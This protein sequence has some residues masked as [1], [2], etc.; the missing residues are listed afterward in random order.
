MD[1]GG[2]ETPYSAFVDTPEP[3]RALPR[4]SRRSGLSCWRALCACFSCDKTPQHRLIR[5][6]A[7]KPT[8]RRYAPNSVKNTKYSLIT[9]VPKL[10]FEQFRY[11]FNMYY[12]LVALSQ[13]FPPLQIGLLFTYIAPL[14]FVLAITM[15][16][17]AYDDVQRWRTDVAINHESYERLLPTGATERVHAQDI[18]VGHLIRVT[19][20]QRVP[21]DLVMLR[22]HDASGM[23]YVRTDQLDGET[24]WK[25]RLAVPSCQKLL[26]D[27]ALAAAVLTLHA[28]PPSRDIYNFEGDLTLCTCRARRCH[29]PAFLFSSDSPL[30][31]AKRA[32][33]APAD[34]SCVPWAWRMQMMSRTRAGASTSRSRSRTRCGQTPSSRAASLAA[35]SCT[36]ASTRGPR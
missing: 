17:E 21:A 13:L 36:R 18:R 26:G 1:M 31:S 35:S 14:V 22:T 11:F 19:T 6:N 24:D 20:D 16:K 34:R 32:R 33:L 30:V 27:G 29:L 15:A 10:L 5:H 23:A 4:R 12:L 9:F 3:Q 7:G 2:G 8:E 25:L 28:A